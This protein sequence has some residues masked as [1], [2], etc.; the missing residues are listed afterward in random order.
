MFQAMQ[1]YL[2]VRY[3]EVYLPT[4]GHFQTNHSGIFRILSFRHIQNPIYIYQSIF[5]TPWFIQAYLG[6]QTQTYLV[7]QVLLKSNLCILSA[8]FR[9]IQRYLAI[10]LIQAINVSGIFTKLHISRRICA[11]SV[12]FQQIQ[13]YSVSWHYRKSQIM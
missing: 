1:P 7:I 3:I 5:K 4:F 13:A 6:P 12:I 9:Q 10:W 11:H 8:L 2:Q